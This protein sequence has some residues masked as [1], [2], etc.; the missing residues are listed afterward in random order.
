M[1]VKHPEIAQ[2]ILDEV[3]SEVVEPYLAQHGLSKEEGA[4]VDL[5]DMYDFAGLSDLSY[6]SNCF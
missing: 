4:S 2:K 3:N 6:I 1:L 5:L